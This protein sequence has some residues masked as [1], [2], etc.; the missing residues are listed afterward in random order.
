MELNN[1]Q[2]KMIK[3]LQ[4]NSKRLMV[5]PLNSSYYSMMNT[6]FKKEQ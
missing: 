2:K 4:E 3:K 1:Y 6:K 5:D